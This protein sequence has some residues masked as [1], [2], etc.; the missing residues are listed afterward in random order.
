MYLLFGILPA[1][2]IR[3][4]FFNEQMSVKFAIIYSIIFFITIS[5]I[6][7]YLEVESEIL[8]T[9]ILP[10]ITIASF[11]ILRATDWHKR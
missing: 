10:F 5:A 6:I 4:V 2:L 1:I 3:Y 9:T 7:H 11:F 8:N